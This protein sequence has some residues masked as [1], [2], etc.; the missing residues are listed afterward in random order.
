[1]EHR[2]KTTSDLF[3]EVYSGRKKF[4]VRLGDKNIKE[5]DILILQEIDENREF[6][7]RE[8]RKKATFVRRTKD[9]NFWSQEQINEQGLVIAQL[10]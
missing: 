10:E 5:G 3:E 1:M 8:V 6:T 2:L 7:G 9:F 4:E